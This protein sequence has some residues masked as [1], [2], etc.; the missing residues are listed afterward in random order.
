M[1]T[2]M[3]EQLRWNEAGL[4]PAIA[5]D[6]E[7][8]QVLM[9]AW[10]NR[11]ALAA[12]LQTRRGTYYSRSRQQLWVK[13]EASGHVQHVRSVRADCD[14]DALLLAIDQVGPA[15][16]TGSRSCFAEVILSQEQ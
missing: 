8:G 14:R 6:A 9:L 12:T 2:S 5:Q 15:C 10:M 11:E 3:V 7:T 1:D 4:I 16:H 13:G